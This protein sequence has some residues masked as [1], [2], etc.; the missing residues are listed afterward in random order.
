M[1]RPKKQADE[2]KTA[3]IHVRAR[4]EWVEW[5]RGLAE[6]GGDADIASLV[7]RLAIREAKRLK[8]KVPPER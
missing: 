1:G 4:P 2:L 7:E 5:F 6:T 3:Y 8:Y